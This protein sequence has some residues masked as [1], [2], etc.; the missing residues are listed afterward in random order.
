MEYDLVRDLDE[1]FLRFPKGTRF[2]IT[3]TQAADQHYLPQRVFDRHRVVKTGNV[4]ERTTAMSQFRRFESQS[5][6]EFGDP[7]EGKK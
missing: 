6:I 4:E 1:P 7:K 5:K 3:L 2:E